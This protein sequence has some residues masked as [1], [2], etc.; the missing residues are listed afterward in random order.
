[1]NSNE[2]ARGS[3][4]DDAPPAPRPRRLTVI[5][6]V[7][8]RRTRIADRGPARGRRGCAA[9]SRAAAAVC[10]RAAAGRV[11]PVRRRGRE[12]RGLPHGAVQR[13]PA[14]RARARVRHGR[15]RRAGSPTTRAWPAAQSLLE[16]AEQLTAGLPPG[17]V[18]AV[19]AD[20]VRVL[21]TGPRLTPGCARDGVELVLEH[22]RAAHALTVVDCGTLARE[23]D[24]IAL[25]KASHV[26]WVLPATPGGVRR[27]ARV[28][29]A[30]DPH[31][32]GRELVVARRDAREPKAA[33]RDLKRLAQR[34]GTPR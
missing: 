4:I 34:R 27:G 28:L 24:R 20:G 16:V 2:V 14:L 26:A 23:A 18:Y 31:P 32:P 30:V 21:A 19:G 5:D 15:R 25:A 10:A 3:R 33:L 17:C 22:A 8:G 7:A 1:M 6:R 13:A 29:D 12:H 11:R 9:A